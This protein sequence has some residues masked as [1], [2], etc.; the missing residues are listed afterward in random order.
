MR[1]RNRPRVSEWQ[2]QFGVISWDSATTLLDCCSALWERKTTGVE[3]LLQ[4]SVF[5]YAISVLMHL[6]KVCVF[7][8][9]TAAA[10]LL[11]GGVMDR[12]GIR[13]P[14]P[15]HNETTTPKLI[16]SAECLGRR[17]AR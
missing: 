4:R 6:G 17:W 8:C 16:G 1:P 10:L 3:G 9:V 7:L 15:T 12:Y 5:S 11:C 13:T 2:Q 14:R